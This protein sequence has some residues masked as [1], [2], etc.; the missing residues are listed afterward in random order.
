MS[1]ET[2]HVMGVDVTFLCGRETTGGAWSLMENVVPRH[3]GPPPH[4]HPWDEAYY[5]I[6]GALR[7]SVGGREQI[8]RRGDF[9]Y[10]PRGTVHAFSGESD[11]PARMLVFDTP[12]H[13]EAFFHEVGREVKEMPRDMAKAVRIAE[14]HQIHFAG[15]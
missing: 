8:A 13:A 10:V 3:A 14:Q 7:F 2:L 15:S 1:R 12:A 11:E 6:D 4:H 9:L 5:V